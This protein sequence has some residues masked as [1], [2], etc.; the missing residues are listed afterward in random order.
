MDDRLEVLEAELSVTAQ[1]RAKPLRFLR[2]GPLW[3]GL[4]SGLRM[5]LPRVDDGE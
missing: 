4:V 3:L 2:Y 1:G 5:D